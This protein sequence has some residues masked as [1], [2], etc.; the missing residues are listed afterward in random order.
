MAG[1][2]EG[3]TEIPDEAPLSDKDLVD[4]VRSSMQELLTLVQDN[5]G[6]LNGWDQDEFRF[7]D[8]SVEYSGRYRY[9]SLSNGVEKEMI[10]VTRRGDGVLDRSIVRI[11]PHDRQMPFFIAYYNL[12]TGISMSDNS[13]GALRGARGIT[14]PPRLQAPGV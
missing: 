10:D 6:F 3:V 2:T 11:N 7:F 5:Y 13:Y 1:M 8:N 9:K 4:G 14:E 12:A